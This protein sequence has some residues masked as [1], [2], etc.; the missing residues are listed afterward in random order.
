MSRLRSLLL[1]LFL[2]P[3]LNGCLAMAAADLAIGVTGDVL[4]GGVNTA[5]AV[6]DVVTPDGDDDEDEDDGEE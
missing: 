6:I 5:G 2:A 3:A 1:I 4:E